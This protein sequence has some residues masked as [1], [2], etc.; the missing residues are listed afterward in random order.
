MAKV[1]GIVS[2]KGGVGKTSI[3]ANIGGILAD[4]GQH[5]LLIDGD[6]Q[7]SL[8]DYFELTDKAKCGLRQFIT[9]ANPS[10]CISGTSIK[11]LDIVISD[12]SDGKLIDWFRASSNNVYYLLASIKK[13]SDHYDYVIKW[14]DSEH[15]HFLFFTPLFQ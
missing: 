12:D 15:L 1:F 5:V 2:T 6:F 8:S 9:A 11:N 4:M 10:G 3:A 14:H 7:Q 13:L